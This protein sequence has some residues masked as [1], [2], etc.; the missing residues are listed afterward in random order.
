MFARTGA[1]APSTGVRTTRGESLPGLDRSVS[2]SGGCSSLP[3]VPM[4][5]SERT[6]ISKYLSR[7]LRH[8]PQRLGLTLAPGGWVDVDQLVAACARDGLMLWRS[9][10]EEVVQTSDK[11]RFSFDATGTRIRANQ[12]HSVPVD[13]ELEATAPPEVLFHGTGASSVPAILRDGLR[14]MRRHHVHLSADK[15]TARRVGARHGVPV[16][17]VVDAAR[18]HAEGIPFYRSENGVWLVDAVPARF[19]SV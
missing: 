4:E 11:Q 17:L 2:R 8:A 6:R 19:L 13:L 12:G 7:H 3:T 5:A 9:T 16:V 18:M 15:E 10:L 14:K 1:G